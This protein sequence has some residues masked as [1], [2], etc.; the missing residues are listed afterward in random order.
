MT[1]INK[2]KSNLIISIREIHINER[3]KDRQSKVSISFWTKEKGVGV[4]GSKGKEGNSQEESKQLM[5]AGSFRKSGAQRG[6]WSKKALLGSSL[7]IS[8]TPYYTIVTYG[9]IF[10]PRADRLSKFFQA[11]SGQ[12]KM[13]KFLSL[14]FIKN[15]HLKIIHMPKKHI[16]GWQILFPYICSYF[17]QVFVLFFLVIFSMKVSLMYQNFLSS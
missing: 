7:S 16:L 8:P 1:Q 15:N 14:L 4:Q 5:F 6:L 11:V 10:L 3:S 13:K 9:D 17:V 12:A 2:R